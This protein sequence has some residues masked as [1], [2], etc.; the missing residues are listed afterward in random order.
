LISGVIFTDG[1]VARAASIREGEIMLRRLN[2]LL[3]GLTAA[4]VLAA[5]RLALAAPPPAK[6]VEVVEPTGP[7][8][9]T[10]QWWQEMLN[11]LVSEEVLHMG[12]N[13]LLGIG[14]FILGWILAKILSTVVFKMLCKTDLDNKLADK[15]GF[16]LLLEDRTTKPDQNA[17]ERAVATTVFYLAMALVVVG[18]LDFAGLEQAAGPIQG[19]VDTIIQALPLIGKAILILVVAWVAGSILRKVVTRALNFAKVDNQFAALDKPEEA[20][21]TPGESVSAKP[22]S[23]TAG[24]VIFWLVMSLGIAG[25]FDALQIKA[26][27]EPLSNAINTLLGLLPVIGIAAVIIVGGYVLGKIARS[28]VTRALQGLGF[29]NL[30]A[31]IRLDGLFGGSS[32]SKVV[33]WVVMA[34]IV[35]QTTIA[36]LDRVGLDTLSAPMTDMMTQFWSLLPAMLVS[37]VF[38]VIGVFVGRLLRGIVTRTLEAVGFDR[39]MDKMGFGKIAERD[40]ELAK[41]SGLVGFIVQ[42]TIVMLAVVQGFN[43]LGLEAWA[44]YLDAFLRFA[45]TRV[46]VALV[47]VGVGFAIGNYVRDLIE[48]R[49]RGESPDP[50]I[51]GETPSPIWM[52]EFA[53]YAVLVFAFTMAVHQLG[54][55]EDFV[56]ITF[57]LLFGALCLAGAL[58]FGLGS[59]ELAGEIVRER[60]KK[61][62]ADVSAP[63]PGGTPPIVGGS[64][65]SSGLFGKPPAK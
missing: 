17:L 56:L 2:S 46:A 37:V 51:V 10:A 47:I 49:Q 59:R 62:K 58:A 3:T 26:I 38:V 18:V 15:L 1:S 45:V 52:A 50:M 14:L 8:F 6:P 34:F 4:L 41:P 39:M 55:A 44:A 60:Y 13:L 43:N 35:I 64:A 23:N 20:G 42:I 57:A 19:F 48:A 16:K 63:K 36:A 30:V 53:R 27:S 40:D 24:T 29:D 22:F 9:M 32:P 7:A 65:S 28:L 11:K 21:T 25:A 54:V 12:M 33:G 31:K 61:V 5:P